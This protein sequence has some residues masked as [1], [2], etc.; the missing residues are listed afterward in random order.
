MQEHK[1][2]F[3]LAR[4]LLLPYSGKDALTHAQARRVI[5]TWFVFFAF[6]LSLGSL[7]VGVALTHS[8]R[9]LVVVFLLTFFGGGTIFALTAGFVIYSLNRTALYQQKWQEQRL[10]QTQPQQQTQQN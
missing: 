10:G 6:V 5:F 3:R 8:V 4:R 9:R 2:R 1:P 7:P